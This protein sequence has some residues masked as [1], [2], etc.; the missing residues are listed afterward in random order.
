VGALGET[1]L[2]VL[3]RRIGFV[4]QDHKLLFD[5]N[6]FE[7]V[8]LPLRVA[9]FA[10]DEAGRRI[11]DPA[12]GPLFADE[13]DGDDLA[14]GTIYVLRSKSDHPVVAAHRDVLHKIGV[15][16]GDVGRRRRAQTASSCTPNR[17]RARS[18]RARRRRGVRSIFAPR[19][20]HSRTRWALGS[21]RAMISI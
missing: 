10:R 14:S 2:A 16:G 11:T 7:N 19:P 17:S 1:A 8:A 20:P 15:T 3:R 5:R 12:A 6:A 9:G 21:T 18:S 13:A 4:F